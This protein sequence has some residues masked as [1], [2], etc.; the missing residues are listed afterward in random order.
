MYACE[1]SGSRRVTI[2]CPVNQT[3]VI[4][5]AMYG[6]KNLKLCPWSE[7]IKPR[8][9]TECD[10]FN[11]ALIVGS[12]CQ[13]RQ[14]CTVYARNSV[15]GDPCPE[16]RKYLEVIYQC[17]VSTTPNMEEYSILPLLRRKDNI[18][19]IKHEA[20]LKFIC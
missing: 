9:S 4:V 17:V 19:V 18:I 7:F 13:G 20:V 12:K 16:T 3:I 6:R 2:H 15:F 1:K 11:S 8:I 5:D 10:A 14:S